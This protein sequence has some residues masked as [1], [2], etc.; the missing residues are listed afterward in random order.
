MN[1]FISEYGI[2]IWYNDSVEMHREDGP[3]LEH[4]NGSKEWYIHG[5]RH[6]SDGPAIEYSYGTNIW[7]Q[8]GSIHRLDGPA[9]EDNDGDNYW[10]IN[11][12]KI[13]CKT[14]EEFLRI[15]KMKELL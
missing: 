11:G 2:K 6:R 9:I 5:V 7:F 4:P 10:Y 3:A 1:P 8:N 14:N 12:Q 13:N 15:V